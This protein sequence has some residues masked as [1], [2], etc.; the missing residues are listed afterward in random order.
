MNISLIAPVVQSLEVLG[1]NIEF[2]VLKL[3]GIL[4]LG[5]LLYYGII[6]QKTNYKY[7]FYQDYFLTPDKESI[8]YINVTSVN[9]EQKYFPDKILG[10]GTLIVELTGSDKKEIKID[11]IEDVDKVTAELN[12]KI[13]TAKMQNYQE[14]QNRQSVQNIIQQW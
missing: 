11:Y 4:A 6:L 8:Y 14:T 5:V 7:I 2:D 3:V 9:Y 12:Q 13:S 10:Y 1:I